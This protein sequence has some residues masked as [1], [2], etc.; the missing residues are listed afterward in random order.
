MLLF[1]YQHTYFLNLKTSQQFN[2]IYL[3]S[4]DITSMCKEYMESFQH[5]RFSAIIAQESLIIP[6]L[7]SLLNAYLHS[8]EQIELS[9]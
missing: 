9:N 3:H 8:K 4:K 7:L 6:L 2:F 5:L 1:K